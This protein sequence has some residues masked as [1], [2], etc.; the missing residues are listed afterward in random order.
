MVSTKLIMSETIPPRKDTLD[1]F[2][3]FSGS[4]EFAMPDT[5]IVSET[6]WPPSSAVAMPFAAHFIDTST[7]RT[8]EEKELIQQ[9]NESTTNFIRQRWPHLLGEA[10]LTSDDTNKAISAPVS[11]PIAEVETGGTAASRWWIAGAAV[12]ATAAA[13]LAVLRRARNRSRG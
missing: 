3:L 2:E 12:A 6:N 4:I 11:L 7:A 9:A 13:G 10:P 1:E 8:P 5:L